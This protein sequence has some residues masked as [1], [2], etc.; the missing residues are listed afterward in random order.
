MRSRPCLVL[1]EQGLADER[2]GLLRIEWLGD[3][4]S[5]F[6]PVVC[7]QASEICCDEVDR[8]GNDFEDATDAVTTGASIGK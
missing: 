4:E 5:G 1:K 3:K 2:F 8:N 7:E 6:G